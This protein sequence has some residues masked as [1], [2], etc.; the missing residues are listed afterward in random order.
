MDTLFQIKLQIPAVQQKL[1]SR[2]RIDYRLNEGLG[3]RLTLVT[4][5]A[6]FGK[7]TAVVKWTEQLSI[8]VAWFSIDSSD[9]SLK[10]FWSYFIAA[11]ETALPG[12]GDR[13]PRY[14]YSADNITAASIVT[15]LIEEM[16]Q[17]KNSFV[18]VIDDYHLIEESSIHDSMALLLK[19]LPANAHIVII[20]RSQPPFN[21][22]RLQTIGYVKEIGFSD[23][24]FTTEEIASL[25][26]VKGVY[27]T[28]RE[29][30]DL[31]ALTEGWA[32]GLCLLLDSAVKDKA[33]LS[34]QSRGFFHDRHRIASYLSEEVVEHWGEAEKN[35]MIKTSILNNLSGSLCDALTGRN[36]GK[37]M[38]ERLAEHNAFIIVLDHENGWYRYH[39]LFSEFLQK[40]LERIPDEEKSKLHEYAGIWYESKGHY[41]EAIEHYLYG[42]HY[43]KAADIIEGR[44]REMLK[45][46]RADLLIN[47]FGILPREL[48]ESRDLLCLT[49]AWALIIT[50][51]EKEAKY[52]VNVVER[53]FCNPSAEYRDEEWK[54][55]LEVEI[56]AARGFIGLKNQ[57]LINTTQSVL[58]FQEIM[59]KGSIFL[60]Y[61]INLN[62]G[63]ASLIGGMFGLKGHLRIAEKEYIALYE[64]VRTFMKIRNGYIPVLMGE[65]LFERNR[66]DEAVAMLVRG[67]REA[68]ESNTIG[69]LIPFTVTYARILKSKGDIASAFAAVRDAEGKIKKMGGFHLISILSAF[70]ARMSLETGDLEAV[71]SWMSRNCIDIFDN[72]G[73]NNIFEY[74]TLARVLK[75][76]KEYDS[77]L[78]LLNRI[79]LFAE[80]ENN[81]LYTLEVHILLAIVYHLQGHAQKAADVLRQALNMGEAH[82]YERIFIEEGAPMAA[83]LAK[84]VRSSYKKVSVETAAETEEPKDFSQHK[85]HDG[86]T[87]VLPV[88]PAY[89]RR[90]LKL[91]QDYCETVKAFEKE[92]SKDEGSSANKKISLTKREKDILHLLDSELTNAEIAYTLNIT[93]N[94]VKVNCSNIYRKLEVKNRERAVRVARELK[95]Q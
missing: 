87:D 49:C 63:G 95:L 10:I 11:L 23:L 67:S 16:Y 2:T 54:K 69:C 52:W 22:I 21:S 44:G 92:R 77:C 4:A 74:L 75:T 76:R 58:K 73:V 72:P 31:E 80:N 24:Q 61:G 50:N 6:G 65:I 84:F 30:M 8:P 39:H 41:T 13:F 60:Y 47:W 29:V 27:A 85:K 68:E 9:N 28:S 25:C 48:V 34:M 86:P 71:E 17:Y 89:A 38:L 53:R 83:L 81:L 35:F 40:R 56:V 7:T 14:L 19:Y 88:S 43:E 45:T 12:L 57:N 90:L 37:E 66:M 55:Q 78:L 62:M 1:A 15:S 51:R 46:G 32:A 94:T 64:N 93:V 42:Y 20:S 59:Q 91:T 18:F 79:K 5:P 26:K 70:K 33:G 82:G 3:G 36:D